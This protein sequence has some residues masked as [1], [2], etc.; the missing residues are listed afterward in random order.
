M[1]SLVLAYP[2]FKYIERRFP[3]TST[4]VLLFERNKEVLDLLEII[5]QENILAIDPGSLT[6][7]T[8]DCI[9][10]LI[11][12]WK[13][14][15]DIIIDCELFSRISSIFSF[16][17]LARVRV[18]FHPHTQEGLYRGNFINRPVLYNPYQHISR[19]FITLVEAIDSGTVPKSK[20]LPLFKKLEAPKVEF[21]H[22][23]I[24]DG[25]SQ[26]HAYS[27]E[28]LG[29]KLV[30]IYPS[31]GLLQIRAWP[32]HYYCRLTSEL[33][34]RGHAVGVIGL[35]DDRKLANAI[36]S[37]C[38]NQRCVDLT[39]YTKSIKELMILFHLASLLITND[40]GP[41]QFAATTPVPTIILFGPE[42]PTLYGSLDEKAVIFYTPVSCS[43][44]LTAFNH[45]NSP[46]DG[47]NLCL[48][49]IQ[50]EAVLVRALQI[51]ENQENS[52]HRHN[53]FSESKC[54]LM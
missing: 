48:R 15:F 17:S 44:C 54:K 5:P 34:Q 52:D 27:P 25:A 12:L 40:G 36:L 20:F 3:D 41:S 24:E 35:D 42:T 10:V 8:T 1:G 19:Q 51:L 32:L 53:N 46:C 38:Q 45:R 23:D 26:L 50:P 39:G 16:L 9:S 31:G 47:E 30:L 28:I 29:R 18:G 14:R 33:L 22:G 43:P 2:M 49:S 37:Y 13:I 21:D 11:K 7:F 4:Y 6:K